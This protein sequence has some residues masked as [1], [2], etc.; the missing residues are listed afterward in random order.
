MTLKEI[1]NKTKKVLPFVSIALGMDSVV[2][3][4]ME[5]NARLT[6]E[7]NEINRLSSELERN[8]DIII[9]HQDTQNKISELSSEASNHITTIKNEQ[10]II[11]ELNNKLKDINLNNSEK[12][13]LIK[14]LDNHFELLRKS[15][16]ITREDLNKINNIINDSIPKESNI[17][18]DMQYVLESYRNYLKT[19]ELE[20]LIA[21]TNLAGYI[22]IFFCLITIICI[23]YSDFLINYFKL[24]T[25]Y[26]KIANFIKLKRQ[27]YKYN[28]IF[29]FSMIFLVII[30]LIIFNIYL[31][32]F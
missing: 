8:K 27:F 2:V 1:L 11:N 30:V 7:A 29:N 16:D 6:H 31:I 28:L 24:E 5:R 4:R 12:D 9:T 19:L 14:E 15:I 10:N 20:Q 25:K 17:L 23:I 18:G 13:N 3:T 22:F 26:P 21:F 32:F